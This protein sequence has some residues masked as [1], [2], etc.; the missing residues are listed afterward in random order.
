[1]K[2][3]YFEQITDNRFSKNDILEELRQ[4]EKDIKEKLKDIARVE[5]KNIYKID[6]WDSIQYRQKYYIYKNT[7]IT[8]NTIYE[9]VNSINAVP[10]KLI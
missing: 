4:R 2:I 6:R 7:W 3:I 8:Y 10:Y 5:T 9:I 1:M